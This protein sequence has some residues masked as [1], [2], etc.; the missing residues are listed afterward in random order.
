MGEDSR[1]YEQ[2]LYKQGWA[3]FKLTRHDASLGPFFDLLDRKLTGIDVQDG[4]NRLEDLSRAEREL[5]EDTFRVLSISFSYMDGAGS[6]DVFLVTRG[7]PEYSY[8]IYM[9]LGDLYLEKERFVDAAE[10]YKAFVEQDPH[11]REVTAAAGR[12]HRSL[13]ARRIPDTRT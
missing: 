8:V 11:Q 4:D 1:F 2:S 6:I 10:T 3:Q 5:I 9:N 7:H 12:G 13:Q